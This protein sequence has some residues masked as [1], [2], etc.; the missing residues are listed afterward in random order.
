LSGTLAGTQA[1]ELGF[2]DKCG[3]VAISYSDGAEY[4]APFCRGKATLSFAIEC[5]D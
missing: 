1:S 5:Y 2:F 4:L 3:H